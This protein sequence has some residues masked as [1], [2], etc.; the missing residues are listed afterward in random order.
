[1]WVVALRCLHGGEA[2]RGEGEGLGM[3]IQ[4]RREKLEEEVKRGEVEALRSG[5]QSR[6]DVLKRINTEEAVRPG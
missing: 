6:G 1:M 2:G 3:E 4:F 5:L